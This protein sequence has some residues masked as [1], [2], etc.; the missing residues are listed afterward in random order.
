MPTQTRE[1]IFD[2]AEQMF[3]E[4]GYHATSVRDIAKAL[5]L[6]AGTLYNHFSSKEDVLWQ[7]VN[8]AADQFLEA[9]EKVADEEPAVRLRKLIHE[10]LR[11]IAANLRNA[12][13]FFHEWKFLAPARRALIAERRNRYEGHFRKAIAD[14]VASGVFAPADPKLAALI[15]LGALNWVYQW[16][17]PDGPLSSDEVADRIHDF[18]ARALAA[19][20]TG[21]NRLKTQEAR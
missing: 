3:A 10:H 14:G 13:V 21:A 9:A 8:R 19:G 1:E 18:T 11:V 15:T 2:T 6:R 5:D 7:I 20:P 16:F 17:R 12:T 4:L